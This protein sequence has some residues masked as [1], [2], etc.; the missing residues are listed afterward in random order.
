MGAGAAEGVV[1][2][3]AT[4]ATL[5]GRDGASSP[6]FPL[7]GA[8][9]ALRRDGL[10]VGEEELAVQP[11]KTSMSAVSNQ[12]RRIEYERAGPGIPARL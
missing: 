9:G 6:A 10:V 8:R 5:A 2:G 1:T 11:A 7:E 4:A 3:L 12:V